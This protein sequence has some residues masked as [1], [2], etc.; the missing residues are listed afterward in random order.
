MGKNPNLAKP[1]LNFG[2]R[3]ALMFCFGL[4]AGTWGTLLRMTF[5]LP[6]C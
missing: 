2:C 3:T 4:S 5:R 6:T 1:E